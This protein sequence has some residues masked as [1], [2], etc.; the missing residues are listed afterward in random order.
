MAGVHAEIRLGTTGLVDGKLS[1]QLES[2]LTA[3]ELLKHVPGAQDFFDELSSRGWQYYFIDG[4]GTVEVELAMSSLPY[5]FQHKEHPRGGFN[6]G[7]S[8]D[9]GRSIPSPQL[10]GIVNLQRFVVNICSKHYPRAVTVDLAKNEITYVHESLWVAEG[11]GGIE[12]AK[13]V[14]E[15]LQWLIEKKGVKLSV[16]GGRERY[17]ELAS[18][19]G[20]K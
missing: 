9:F 18:L 12:E 8:V 16:S 5:T 6:Y 7:L 1:T 17:Q 11:K 19:L 2:F 10:K 13:G 4:Y 20:G 14:L 3:E 15:I